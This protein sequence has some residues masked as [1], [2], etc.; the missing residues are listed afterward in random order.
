MTFFSHS[1]VDQVARS[2]PEYGFVTVRDVISDFPKPDSEVTVRLGA[3]ELLVIYQDPKNPGQTKRQA[4]GVTRM[5]C[6]KISGS[7][8]H[9]LE[10]SFDYLR[11]KDKLAWTTYVRLSCSTKFLSVC[12]IPFSKDP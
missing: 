4:F 5:R 3:Y 11:A 8:D 7:F 1:R 2:L 9:G 10:I 6:W 12:I